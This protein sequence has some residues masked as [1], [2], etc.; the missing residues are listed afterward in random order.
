MDALIATSSASMKAA[1]TGTWGSGLDVLG[2]ASTAS[3]TLYFLKTWLTYVIGAGFGLLQAL[4]PYIIGL[5][6]IGAIVYMIFRAFRF[7]RH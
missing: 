3:S 5:I 2:P 4:M 1:F 6:V 7:F